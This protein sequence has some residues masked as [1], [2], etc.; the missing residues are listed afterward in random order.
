MSYADT[1]NRTA[2]KVPAWP[3]YILGALPVVWIYYQGLTGALGIDPVKKIEH[4]LGEWALWLLIAGLCVTPLRKYAG[5]NL[6][7]FR[8]AVGLLAFFYVLA[9]FL[10]W[11]LLDL[12]LYWGQIG[13]DIVKRPYI[14]VGFAAFLLLIPLAVT[15]NNWSIRKMGGTA[16]RRLHWLIY[17]AVLL[18]GLH[19]IWLAKGFQ[20]EPLLYMTAILALLASRLR[21]N[22]QRVAA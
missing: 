4:Q 13:K 17:P 5:L 21:W 20:L 19:F 18:G 1:I 11:L 8:R 15:S 16:W 14:T 10:T 9:H 2:R 3:L 6:L 7:K 22:W 12:Q